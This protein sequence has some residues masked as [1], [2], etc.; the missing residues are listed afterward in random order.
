MTDDARITATEVGKLLAASPYIAFLGLTCD[1]LDQAGGAITLRMPMRPEL[2][3][4]GGTGQFH[5]GPIAGLIDTAGDF[6]IL[7]SVGAPIPTVNFRVDYLRPAFGSHLVAHARARRVGRSVG[8]AD[9][10]VVDAEGRLLA[11]GRGTY[12]TVAG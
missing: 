7:L 10:D 4:S 2:E 6:A 8:V 3:R 9:V 1:D 5:G 12:S 11:I